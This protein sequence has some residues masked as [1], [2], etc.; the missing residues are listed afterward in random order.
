MWR[1][2][3]GRG[4]EPFVTQTAKWTLVQQDE[5]CLYTDLYAVIFDW[6]YARDIIISISDYS[7]SVS[8][9]I[10]SSSYW[11]CYYTVLFSRHEISNFGNIVP[12][13]ATERLD[14]LQLQDS[15]SPSAINLLMVTTSF[16]VRFTSASPYNQSLMS[17]YWVVTSEAITSCQS[18]WTGGGGIRNQRNCQRSQQDGTLWWFYLLLDRNSNK[19]WRRNINTARLCKKLC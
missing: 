19:I 12:Q 13:C 5:Y 10:N 3:F 8:D 6:S 15:P 14:P 17:F 16:C 2:H 4:F 9:D 1:A 7:F 11:R 18:I